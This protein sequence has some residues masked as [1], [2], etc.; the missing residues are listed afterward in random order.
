MNGSVVQQKRQ[1]VHHERATPMHSSGCMLAC[2]V[3]L[4]DA[5]YTTHSP[6]GIP[7]DMLGDRSPLLPEDLGAPSRPSTSTL[8]S[9]RTT[10]TG[11]RHWTGPRLGWPLGVTM[12]S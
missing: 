8:R 5:T 1:R 9:Y 11:R 2:D 12:A 3:C 6:M 4:V 7:A 10:R